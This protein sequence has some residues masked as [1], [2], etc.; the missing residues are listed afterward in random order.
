MNLSSAAAAIKK[1]LVL[2][3]STDTN[4]YSNLAIHRLLEHGHPVVGVGRE[5]GTVGG[6]TITADLVKYD[7]I[8]T[9]TMYVNPYNQHIFAD[10]VIDLAPKRVIFNPGSENPGLYARLLAADIEV[11]VACTLVLLGTQQY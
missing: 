6:A 2:G 8:H 9:V 1:T 7:D 4:R 3:A 5:D 10:Y 11:E